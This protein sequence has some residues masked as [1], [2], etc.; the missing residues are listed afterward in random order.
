MNEEQEANKKRLQEIFSRTTATRKKTLYRCIHK[1]NADTH[2]V[3][4]YYF[5]SIVTFLQGKREKS[6]AFTLRRR[7]MQ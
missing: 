3:Y 7:R 1:V 6:D 5:L 4:A 2:Y